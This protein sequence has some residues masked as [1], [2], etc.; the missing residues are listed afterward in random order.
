M[1]DPAEQATW[2]DEIIREAQERGEFDD[3]PGTGEPVPGAGKKDDDLWW[4][5]SWMKRNADETDDSGA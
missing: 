3:L 5:R 4:V 1:K 2:I